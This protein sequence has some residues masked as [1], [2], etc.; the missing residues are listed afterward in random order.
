MKLPILSSIIIFI[1]VLTHTIKRSNR[2]TE[3]LKKEYLE[4]ERKANFTRRKSLD[5]LDYIS[6]PIEDLPMDVLDSDPQ[7]TQCIQTVRELSSEKI[8][9]F[10]GLTNTDLKLEYGTANIDILTTY[11]TRYTLLA[12]TLQNWGKLLFEADEL[13][14]AKSVL[15]F[16]ISTKTDVKGSYEI[17]IQIYRQLDTPEKIHELISVAKQLNSAMKDPIVHTL[18]EACQ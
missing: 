4:R 6:I 11:D 10:T 3:K 18:Q 16:A 14:A 8:V 2:T 13:A 5:N 15:E 1:L 12:R 9:N 17:L 7:I